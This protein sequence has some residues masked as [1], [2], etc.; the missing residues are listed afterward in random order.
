MCARANPCWLAVAVLLAAPA[1]ASARSPGEQI[2]WAGDFDANIGPGFDHHLVS[3]DHTDRLWQDF[4]VASIHDWIE[5]WGIRGMYHD[6]FGPHTHGDR[7]E[8]FAFCELANRVYT[9]HRRL[10]P[11]ALTIVLAQP[12]VPC[13]SFGD[14]ILSG[15]MYRGPLATDQ[16][17]PAFMTLPEFRA[18]NVVALGP[19]RMI[20]PQY[21]IAYRDSVPHAVH[22]MGIFLLHDLTVYASWFN[23]DVYDDLETRRITFGRDRSSFHGYWEPGSRGQ[24]ADPGLE[25]SYYEKP[26]GLLIA[27]ANVTGEDISSSLAIDV[28]GLDPPDEPL[29]RVYDPL[30][31]TEQAVPLGP[32]G[33]LPV[34]VPA[35]MM[36]LIQIGE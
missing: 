16:W 32:D 11:D 8:I 23:M 15:E 5:R 6:C 1:T 18:E 20:L 30:T 12:Y 33:A 27:A 21:K 31:Q 34:E 36:L 29:A 25:V 24:A 2:I 9:M 3:V 28:S 7:V 4:I 35:W 10:C 26:S 14:A 22:A 17:Y 13:I 19:S